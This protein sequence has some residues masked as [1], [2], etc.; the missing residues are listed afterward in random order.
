MKKTQQQNRFGIWIDKKQATIIKVA[1]DGSKDYIK[2]KSHVPFMERFKGETT[3]K[4]GLFGTTLSR[5][6]KLQEKQNNSVHHF[7]KEVVSN[8][9]HANAILILGSGDTR[10]ELQNAIDKSKSMNGVW[11]ENKPSPKIPIRKIETEMEKH[12]NLHFK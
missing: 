5:E 6:K 4:T 2:V 10:F 1:P 11:V 3:S 7:I 8:L 9:D 12:F